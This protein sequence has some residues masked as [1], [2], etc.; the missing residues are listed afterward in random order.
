VTEPVGTPDGP[1]ERRRGPREVLGLAAP[2]IASS[3]IF[4]ASFGIL[5]RAAGFGVVAPIVMSATTFGGSAQFAAVSVLG[6]G[7]A[8][9]AAIVAAILLNS[10]YL[11]IGLSVAPSLRGSAARRAVIGHLVVDESW[12]I[13]NLGDGRYD[14]R[15]LVGVG[16]LMFVGWVGGT[17]AGVFGGGALGD[18]ARFG[19]DAAFPALFLALL[20]PQAKRSRRAMQAAALGGAIAFVLIPF[21]PPGVPIIAA[22]AACLLGLRRG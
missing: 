12:A 10:R 9:L 2:F 4:G 1:A 21:T 5:A 7:G 6:G 8:P 15:T 19:L 16:C 11:A 20:V 18:P 14:V 3:V 13:S 17:A 22:S